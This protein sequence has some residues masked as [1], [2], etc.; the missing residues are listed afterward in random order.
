VVTE[1]KQSPTQAATSIWL[2]DRP[3]WSQRNYVAVRFVV[4]T[5]IGGEINILDK[6]F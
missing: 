6:A 1:T 2:V 4:A 3:K 5:V